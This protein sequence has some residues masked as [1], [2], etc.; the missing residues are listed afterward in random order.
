[1]YVS[2]S[3][4]QVSHVHQVNRKLKAGQEARDA[5]T[6]W[7]T[8]TFLVSFYF[9]A[10]WHRFAVRIF[11]RR[12]PRLISIEFNQIGIRYNSS[13]YAGYGWPHTPTISP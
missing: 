6:G 1:L 7:L 13:D 11:L 2:T 4:F 3:E 12:K 10:A 5:L 9:D 8:I